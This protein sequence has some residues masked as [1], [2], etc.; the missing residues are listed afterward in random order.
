VPV[1][2]SYPG[3]YI[4]E[5]LSSSHA[6]VPAP[7][8]VAAFVGYAHPFQTQPTTFNV[9]QQCFS[10]N[11]YQTHFG[12]LFSSGLV[13]ASL[14]RAVN[15]FFLNGGSTAWV[16]G[17]QPGLFDSNDDVIPGAS[18]FGLA[19]GEVNA[20][21]ATASGG[22]AAA[23]FTVN[24]AN[25]VPTISSLSPASIPLNTP[26][27][28][29]T[30]NGSN[31]VSGSTVSWSPNT[32]TPGPTVTVVSDTQLTVNLTLGAAAADLP[33][34]A[35]VFQITVTNPGAPSAGGTSA[36]AALTV[37]AASGPAAISSLSPS[38]VAV[39]SP[40]F[41]LTING[42][43]FAP[44]ATVSW[45]PNTPTT[46]P[47][48][49]FV[50]SAQLTLNVTTGDFPSTAGPV[51]I[52]VTNP[53]QAA[54]PSSTFSVT[55]SNPT[56]V[57]S[58]L[59]PASVIAGGEAFNLTLSGSN[60]VPASTV[61]L[62]SGGA[63]LTPVSVSSSQLVVT[64]PASAIASATTSLTVSVSNPVIGGGGG[65]SAAVPLAVN[66]GGLP[67]PTIS[68]V[69]P[70]SVTVGYT[71][72]LTLTVNGANFV[73]GSTVSLNGALQ[74][75]SAV[76]IVSATQ[77]TVQAPA[78]PAGPVSLTV[79]SPSNGV[80]IVFTAMEFTDI[81]P[82]TVTIANVNGGTFDAVITYGARIETYR[83]IQLTGTAN[84]QPAGVINPLS[85]L[86][87]VAP[88]TGGYGTTI[89]KQ[90]ISLTFNLPP[91]LNT[92]FSA[93]D[94]VPAFEA[95]SS[96]DN[97][98]IFNLLI[99]PGVTDFSIVSAAL[100]FAERKLAFAILDPPP[101]APAFG[102][103]AASPQP[104]QYWME[105][106]YSPS[107]PVLPLS[108]NGALY[109]PY[110]NSNDPITASNIPMAPSGFVAGV[111]AATDASRGVWKA[112][113]GLAANL[114]NTTGPVQSG[115]MN[116]PEQGVLNLDSINCLRS[117]SA[118]GTV[119]WGARTLVA[120]NSA[121]QQSKYVPV[122]RMTLF[123]EQTLLA[124]LRWVVFEPNGPDLWIAIKSTIESFL[125][126]LYRQGALQGT[127]PDDA[128]QVKCDS[129]T[130][131]TTDQQNGIVNIVVGFAPLKP[132]EFVIIQ[133]AQLAG[134]TAGS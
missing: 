134:Q 104:I 49:T 127:T 71:A 65:T 44:G 2:T 35:G 11:D 115:V 45:T 94:F 60:F 68:S 31:F 79:T 30:I 77:L 24:A 5:L 130:T 118:A 3:I 57:L 103:S 15:Q 119:V 107:G 61:M 95:T 37:S 63:P 54:S 12:P 34:T 82:M 108:Q 125:L 59:S 100:A 116:D 13:D 105:G 123:I 98:E 17:L 122:R 29:L 110:L 102:S 58:S 55:S 19:S 76:S 81:V 89:A 90:Q 128:F 43:N 133:I 129:T 33:N 4:Q 66:A 80:G 41:L 62:S 121:Y 99:V 72:P 67:A 73:P 109:F 131:T 7:T 85:K 20:S 48:A 21:G 8:S 25:L 124:N 53:G 23:T 74:A 9:A 91:T 112:P 56:P 28:T 47:T 101:Q 38:S 64:V 92:C 113:A 50:S 117:F 132:A 36:G 84:Q 114:T 40:S 52:T 16:V 42:S 96:L 78:F 14:P 10:F 39:G 26:S 46:A 83:G 88:A 106:L 126:S 18:R 32:P 87:Q 51:N 22:T 27:F 120:G 93:A 6:I 111:Y 69:S 86:V 1:S 70:A 75:A 97:L